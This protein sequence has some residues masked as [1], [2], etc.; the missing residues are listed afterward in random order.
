MDSPRIAAQ[1][2]SREMTLAR[3][4]LLAVAAPVLLA[5]TFGDPDV[6]AAPDRAVAQA[7]ERAELT[8][9]CRSLI[10]VFDQAART[11]SD[12]DDLRSALRLRTTAATECSDPN[13]PSLMENGI[14]DLHMAL[15]IIGVS[16]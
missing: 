9:R 1:R 7:Q 12:S 5:A 11:R 13:A 8:A 3:Y 15:H 10:A 16:E 14:D 2:R 6:D 4:A